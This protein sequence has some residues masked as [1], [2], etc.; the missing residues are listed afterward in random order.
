MPTTESSW[1]LERDRHD[2]VQ[3]IVPSRNEAERLPATLASLRRY[4]DDGAAGLGSRIE[5]IVVDNDSSDDTARLAREADSP[6]LPIRVVHCDRLG[7]GAAV[8]AGV[9][10][11]DAHL[12]GFIDAD[13]ATSWNALNAALELLGAGAD[14]AI[15]SRALDTSSV[16]APRGLVRRTGAAA[17][18][19]A[20]RSIVPTFSD[21]QC[22]FKVLR[23]DLARQVFADLRATG[24]SFD[25]ELLA[26]L[27]SRNSSVVEFGVE[28]T[29]VPGSTFRPHFDGPGA[30]VELGRIACRMQ[31][32]RPRGHHL[33][34]SPPVRTVT[35]DLVALPFH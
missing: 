29:D 30:L 13:G 6:E 14:A 33:T 28:W 20:A 17:F 15:G 23:G 18:R 9:A 2:V 3:L 19:W 26:R 4:V 31:L 34:W 22:G 11:S 12:V 32:E 5:V 21:T 35:P 10:V 7:K 16:Q 27:V 24:F 25:V 1:S 8:R